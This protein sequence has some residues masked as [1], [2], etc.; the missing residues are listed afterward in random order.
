MQV[1]KSDAFL[2][3]FFL[4]RFLG[5]PLLRSRTN[6]THPQD[7]L[8][9]AQAI[10]PGSG[11]PL[12]VQLLLAGTV[13][14]EVDSFRRFSDPGVDALLVIRAPEMNPQ[15]QGAVRTRD[16]LAPGTR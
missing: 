13:L 3:A 15:D 8:Q 12:V 7:R 10:T 9:A 2:P 4:T 5:T 16:L 14:A 6:Q 1:R 11:L